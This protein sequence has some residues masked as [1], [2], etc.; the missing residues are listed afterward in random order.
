MRPGGPQI[1]FAL[2][3]VTEFALITVTVAGRRRTIMIKA[4]NLKLATI[5]ALA[6]PALRLSAMPVNIMIVARRPPPASQ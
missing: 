4:Y 5:R 3:T 2:I 1:Q 6:C